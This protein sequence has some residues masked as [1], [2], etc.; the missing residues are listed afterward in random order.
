MQILEILNDIIYLR[1]IMRMQS[2]RCF[3]SITIEA[4]SSLCH[5]R[6]YVLFGSNI[7]RRMLFALYAIKSNKHA[8]FLISHQEAPI[9]C[10]GR[11]NLRTAGLD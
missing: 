6:M 3:Q 10:R 1:F 9:K 2:I 7:M 5:G 8:K 4:I 11:L